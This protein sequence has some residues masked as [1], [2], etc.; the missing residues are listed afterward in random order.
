MAPPP[1]FYQVPGGH[2]REGWQDVSREDDFF[3]M[4]SSGGPLATSSKDMNCLF[5]YQNGWEFIASL[6]HKGCQE[7]SKLT[8]ILYSGSLGRHDKTPI[9]W[10]IG[11]Q[12][13]RTGTTGCTQRIS[14]PHLL[15][16]VKMNPTTDP[17]VRPGWYLVTW[18]MWWWSSQYIVSWR[19]RWTN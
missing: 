15:F 12:T 5:W 10:E 14:Q 13:G 11:A 1:W 7:N 9:V 16:G 3:S 4:D 2:G 6:S 18:R 8:S 17:T 19:W